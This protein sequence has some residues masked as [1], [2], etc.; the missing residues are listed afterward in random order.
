MRLYDKTKFLYTKE[1]YFVT[2]VF[3]SKWRYIDVFF[4][5]FTGTAYRKALFTLS[6]YRKT[7]HQG[8]VYAKGRL[9]GVLR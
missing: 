2:D 3:C 6:P 9:M 5:P 1:T 8:W 7:T 4:Y